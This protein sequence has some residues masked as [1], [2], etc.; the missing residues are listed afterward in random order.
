MSASRK[1]LTVV[2]FGATGD[3]FRR[4]LASALFDLSVK[5]MLPPDTEIIG[6]AR[7]EF[8]HDGFRGLLSEWALSRGHDGGERDIEAF[9]ARAFYHRGDLADKKSYDSLGVFM[10]ERDRARDVCSD[11]IFYLAVPPNLYETVFVRLARSGLTIPCAPGLPD[12]ARAWARVLVEKPFGSDEREAERLD[13]LLGKLFSEEQIFRIDHYLAKETLQNI[14]SFRFSNGL[15]EPLWSYHHIE[16]VEIR[17]FEAD[18]IENRGSFYDGIGALRD[19]GQNHLLQM[20]ALVAMEHPGTFKAEAIREARRKVLEKVVLPRGKLSS[21]ITRGQYQGY[22]LANGV[23][24]DSKT[25][26]Y[27]RMVAGISNSRWRGTRFILEGGKALNESKVEIAVFFKPAPCLCPTNHE[28]PHQNVLTFSIAP[29]EGISVLFWAKQPGF[30]SGLEPKRLSF[31][32]AE[33]ALEHTIPDAYERVLYDSIRGDQTLFASTG[34]VKAEW[35]FITPILEK[36]EKLPL[37]TYAKGST[38]PKGEL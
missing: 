29:E 16:R 23:A 15:F 8:S 25:E 38:G 17:M 10:A 37:H 18:G 19:V 4:K 22:L 11:K 32:F 34:E 33:G 31:S 9:A 5:K 24:N 20:L 30:E 27:F 13:K 1:P 7:K 35:R 28:V 6:F 21:G 3:L 36:W 2:V 12:E 14:I 26:T